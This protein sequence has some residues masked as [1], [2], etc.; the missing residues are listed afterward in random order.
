MD[1]RSLSS[2]LCCT[3]ALHASAAWA[4]GM[5]SECRFTEAPIAIDARADEPAW[6]KA[7]AIEE[8]LVAGGDRGGEKPSAATRVRLLWDR[9]HLYVLAECTAAEAGDAVALVLRPAAS[10]P[11]HYVFKVAANGGVEAD[12]FEDEAAGRGGRFWVESA[13]SRRP[14]GEPPGWTAELRI[15]WIAFFRTWGRPETGAEWSFAASRGDP[16]RA[17][18]SSTARFNGR[19]AALHDLAALGTLRF[20]PD[21]APRPFGIAVRPKPPVHR[22]QGSPDPPPPYTIE[23]AFPQAR[24]RHVIYV[25]QQPKSDRLLFVSESYGA[26]PSKVRRIPDRPD[27]TPDDIETLLDDKTATYVNVV[28]YSIAFH[29]RFAENGLV[30]IGCNSGPRKDAATEE[31]KKGPRRTRVLRYRMDPAP[32]WRLDLKSETEI[33]SW[34]SDGHNGG[35]VAFGNDGLLYVTSGD[36]SMDSDGWLTGQDLTR[37]NAKVLRIDVDHPDPG[38]E[39]SVPKDNPFVGQEGI[40]PETWAYGLRN[41]W[42][43]DID[44]ETGDVWVG[45]NGQDITEQVYLIERGANY[46][47]SAHEGSR[48]FVPARLAGPSPFSPPTCEHDHSEARSLTGGIVCRDMRLADLEGEYVYGD[49]VTGRIWSVP[50]DDADASKPRLLADTR[51]MITSFARNHAGDLLV[52]DFYVGAEGGIYRIVPRPPQEAAAGFPRRLSETG[53]FA[54][55]PRHEM[56]AGAIPYDVNAPQ[57]AD[58]AEAV[59]FFVLPER[60]MQRQPQGH[61]ADVPA[62]IRVESYQGWKLPDASVVVQ[63][64]AFPGKPGDPASR[65]WIETRVLLQNEG[66]WA[67]Y[68]YRWRDDQ[69]DADLVAAEGAEAEIALAAGGTQR[70]RFPSRAECMVCHSQAA[71]MLLGLSTV[72]FNRDFDYHAAL[73]GSATTDSQLRTLEHLGLVE[74]DV[75]SQARG[76]I[77]GLVQREVRAALPAPPPSAADEERKR[78]EKALADATAALDKSCTESETRK[79]AGPVPAPRSAMLFVPPSAM[80]RLVDPRNEAADLGT[81]V[82]S[83]LHANCSCCHIGAGGGNSRIMFDFST[84]TPDTQAIDQKPMHATFDLT[85]ARIVAPGAPERSILHYRLSRRGQAQMPPL[86]SAVVDEAAVDLVRRWIESLPTE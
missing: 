54:S 43:L 75:D 44:R 49:H 73:G 33:I 55:V 8:F 67:G 45:N 61:V 15:P 7:A 58:G 50:H 18:W 12:F 52:T 1:V 11:D 10:R 80:P 48:P 30:Y 78:F 32:P 63:S 28:H 51:L 84:P 36:G 14:A 34:V 4:A 20:A 57:W 59:R 64:L 66:D 9:E 29:P 16:A 74:M 17:G 83:Y 68:T 53:L 40:R 76:R 35:A 41:P 47:W 22:M 38:R 81:R 72:Q 31:E 56:A 21:P 24:L 5:A 82:R 25:C 60:M 46:G 37:L 71:N 77:A 85:D 3:A 86:G 23:S 70:W 26:D 42:R 39:Y 27:A 13:T 65:K 69:Q 79:A 62:R 19:P 2:L 6:A